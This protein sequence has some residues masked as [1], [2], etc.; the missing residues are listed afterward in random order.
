[1]D[2]SSCIF[3]FFVV[4]WAVVIFCTVSGKMRFRKC[5]NVVVV[6]EVVGKVIDLGKRPN[7][8]FL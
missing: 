3:F 1:M 7:C 2:D 6:K 4:G 5:E 8:L